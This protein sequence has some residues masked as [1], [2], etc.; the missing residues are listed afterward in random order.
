M[1]RAHDGCYRHECLRAPAIAFPIQSAG[2]AADFFVR[3]QHAMA[4]NQNRNRIRAARAAHGADGLWLANRPRD[5]AVA[6]RFAGG[7]F[8]QRVPDAFLKFRSR[9]DPA[10]EVFWFAPG[11][12]IFQRGFGCRDASCRFV[13]G[14]RCR[15]SRLD[16]ARPPHRR[17]IQFRQTFFRI[18]RDEL[19][20]ARGDGQFEQVEFSWVGRLN[21]CG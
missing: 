2:E 9:P 14:T 17:E 18:A 16:A 1:S 10:A 12:N 4:R 21:G 8:P 15:R 3:G 13:A 6:F 20:V 11:Q 5:F 19:A 7:N